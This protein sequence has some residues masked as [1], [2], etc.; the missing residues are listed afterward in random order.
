MCRRLDIFF[1]SISS[2][3]K[4]KWKKIHLY[5]YTF[6]PSFFLSLSF[7]LSFFWIAFGVSLTGY[8]FWSCD[9]GHLFDFLAARCRY[10]WFT[11]TKLD[12]LEQGPKRVGPAAPHCHWE[13]NRS[14]VLAKCSACNRLWVSIELT[15]SISNGTDTAPGL[16]VGNGGRWQQQQQQQ[17]IA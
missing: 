12:E 15:V 16:P 10:R 2:S 13:T 5:I 17:Q 8:F 7:R 9:V 3:S 4:K 1:S 14:G 6:F 11:Q